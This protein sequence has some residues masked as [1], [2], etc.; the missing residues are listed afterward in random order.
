MDVTADAAD[1][2]LGCMLSC[3]VAYSKLSW[4]VTLKCSHEMISIHL[5][6]AQFVQTDT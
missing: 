6:G 1:F 4:P 2:G 3:T 5:T